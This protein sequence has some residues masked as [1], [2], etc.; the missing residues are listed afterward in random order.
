[1]TRIQDD[2]QQ[3]IY[4]RNKRVDP[5]ND[6]V[7][8]ALYRLIE[9]IGREHLGQAGSP[10]S[11]DGFDGVQTRLPQPG[12]GNAM[13]LYLERYIYDTAGNFLAMQHRG[14]DPD[15]PGWTRN[16]AYQETS[17]IEPG[18]VSNRL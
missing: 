8:D 14:T 18:K 15:S 2:A 3:A 4:F 17:L 9:A 16:Y 12:D 10:T 6:Y 7:Y 11:P 13:G 5:S 1:I